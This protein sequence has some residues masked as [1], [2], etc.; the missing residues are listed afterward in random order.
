MS[1]ITFKD[2]AIHANESEPE[3]YQ[4]E[5]ELLG[6]NVADNMNVFLF[7]LA[8]EIWGTITHDVAVS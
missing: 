4:N 1:G 6:G 8:P 3:M 7:I 2:V 5:N